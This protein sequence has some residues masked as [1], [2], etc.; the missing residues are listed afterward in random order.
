MAFFRAKV[1]LWPVVF[2]AV[3]IPIGLAT[4]FGT[5]ALSAVSLSRIFTTSSSARS[6]EVISAVKSIDQEV[7]LAMNVRDITE[8]NE[9]STFLGIESDLWDRAVFVRYQFQAKLGV[10]GEDVQISRTGSSRYSVQISKFVF[11]GTNDPSFEV[12][13]EENGI[14]AFVTPEIDTHALRDEIENDDAAHER[15]IQ[16]NLELLHGQAEA[17]YTRIITAIDP[18]AVVSFEFGE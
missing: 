10:D 4:A 18:A 3:L 14:L 5:G 6:T 8:K 2:I 7:L 9:S 11:I 17:V 15:Y 1:L 13:T 12:V 16:E